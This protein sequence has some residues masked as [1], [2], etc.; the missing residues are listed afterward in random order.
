MPILQWLDR[1][2]TLTVA[3]N[4]PYRM[5]NEVKEYSYGDPQTQN[6]IVQGDNL[7]GLKALLPLKVR[8]FRV[9]VRLP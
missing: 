8:K 2:K 5:L 7:E 3:Q 9:K 6:M 4:T 1:D